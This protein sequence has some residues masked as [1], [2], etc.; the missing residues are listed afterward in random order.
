MGTVRAE[1]SGHCTRE[2]RWW[3]QGGMGMVVTH[4]GSVITRTARACVSPSSG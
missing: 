3:R 2:H 4:T 1:E